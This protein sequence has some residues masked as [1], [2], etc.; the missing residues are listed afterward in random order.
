MCPWWLLGP[1]RLQ[2]TPFTPENLPAKPCRESMAMAMPTAMGL[3]GLC[4]IWGQYQTMCHGDKTSPR[5]NRLVI[6]RQIVFAR[7][8]EVG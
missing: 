3:E 5:Q 2:K 7:K 6:F 4:V 1:L 8:M